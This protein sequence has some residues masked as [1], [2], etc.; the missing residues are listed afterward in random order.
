MGRRISFDFYP[1]FFAVVLFAAPA[2]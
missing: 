2:A 1:V